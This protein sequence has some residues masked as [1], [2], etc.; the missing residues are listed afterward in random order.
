MK[1][2]KLKPILL[3]DTRERTPW[4]FSNDEEFGEIKHTKVDA[5]DYT[6]EG[7]ETI[8]TIERKAS[9]DELLNNFYEN[10]DRIL[11]EFDRMKDYKFKFIVVEQD[12]ETV[13]N[14]QSY[15]INR[16][17]KNRRSPMVPVAVVMENLIN[18]ML[19]HNVHVIFAGSKAAKITKRLLLRAYELHSK[20]KL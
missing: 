10:K 8:I 19:E 20:G 6:I 1:K 5:G 14:P 13:M 11:A 7:M 17:K 18:I 9:A 2:T 12:L 15:Y 3:V 16:S 4:D